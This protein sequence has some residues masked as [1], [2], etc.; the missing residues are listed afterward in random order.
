VGSGH[1]TRAAGAGL[2]ALGLLAS[3]GVAHAQPEPA[4]PGPPPAGR[5]E[6]VFADRDLRMNLVGVIVIRAGCWGQEGDACVGRI[7]ARLAH[8][9][10]ARGSHVGRRTRTWAPFVLGRRGF[11]MGA[12]LS[13]V[14]RLRFYPRGGYLTRLAGSIPVT[15]TA[16]Y[17]STR[18]GGLTSSRTIAVYVPP[19]QRY[20]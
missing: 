2:A 17:R 20:R 6:V 10:R 8:P 18:R 11:T 4:Q 1:L 19:L 16:R 15:L 9:I 12:G 5:P 7:E 14:I 3:A 13:R